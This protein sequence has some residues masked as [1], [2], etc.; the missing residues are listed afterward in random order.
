VSSLKCL[1]CHWPN[2]NRE[3]PHIIPCMYITDTEQQLTVYFHTSCI[4]LSR[5]CYIL[6]IWMA[7][8]HRICN[9][10]AYSHCSFHCVMAGQL[11]CL[12]VL[13]Y[14]SPAG[15]YENCPYCL[16]GG[17]FTGVSCICTQDY[18]GSLCQY[19]NGYYTSEASCHD[20]QLHAI[21][22]MALNYCVVT[23]NSNYSVWHHHLHH[24]DI[25]TPF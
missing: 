7:G 23:S 1:N 5:A 14:V 21:N 8:Q 4:E 20:P 15:P 10:T 6:H 11:E 3:E 12:V 18:Y 16:H 13:L 24:L 2:V 25:C 17:T 22:R 19:S 9:S